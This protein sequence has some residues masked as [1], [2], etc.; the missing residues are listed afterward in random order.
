MRVD[1][2][3]G[4]I[5]LSTKLRGHRMICS[6]CFGGENGWWARDGIFQWD[7]M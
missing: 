6:L 7:L 5:E 3:G 2:G 4:E 1:F